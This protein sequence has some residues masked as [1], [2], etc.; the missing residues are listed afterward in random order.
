MRGTH[1]YS[2]IARIRETTQLLLDLY[3]VD[4]RIYIHPLKVWQRYSP[5]MFFPHLIRGDE[6]VS[7]TASTEVA[8][9]FSSM[10]RQGDRLDHWDVAFER[11]RE[12]LGA[13]GRASRR[14]IKRRCATCSSAATAGCSACAQVLH[15]G[16]RP[17]DR[18]PGGGQRA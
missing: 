13:A 2:T 4:G 14:T 15:I 16:G 8:D 6:A 5:T 17:C 12:A 18:L 3:Q 11:A 7:I 9:L 1:T 10:Q